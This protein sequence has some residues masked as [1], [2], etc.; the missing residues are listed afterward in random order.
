MQ[1]FF[2]RLQTQGVNYC[3]LRWFDDLPLV[4]VGEDLD[5]LVSDDS[6]LTLMGNVSR[7]FPRGQKLDVYSE[8]GVHTTHWHGIPYFP[9]KLSALLLRSVIQ[10]PGGALVPSREAHFLSLAYHAVFHKGF[11]SGISAASSVT[12]RPH[13]PDHDYVAAL[14]TLRDD[15][16]LHRLEISLEGLFKYLKR[17]GYFPSPDVLEFLGTKNK[18]VASVLRGT[19][20]AESPSESAVTVFVIRESALPYVSDLRGA[21]SSE[22]FEVLMDFPLTSG[23]TAIVRESSRGGNWAKGPFPK[24]GGGPAHLIVT[25]D[26]FPRK[27]AELGR[28]RNPFSTNLRVPEV[29]QKI[30]DIV[31]RKSSFLQHSNSVHSTDNALSTEFLLR[32]LLGSAETRRVYATAQE[33]FD[34]VSDAYQRME[35]GLANSRRSVTGFSQLDGSN[36]A[37]AT[38]TFRRQCI[39]F[40]ERELSAREKLGDQLGVVPIAEAGSNFFSTVLIEGAVP[41]KILTPAQVRLT[42]QFLKACAA[43]GLA[44]VD[45]SPSNM[46]V[47]PKGAIHFLDFEFFQPVASGYPIFRSVALRGVGRKSTLEVPKGFTG[48]GSHYYRRWFRHTLLPRWIYVL[49]L[50]DSTVRSLQNLFGYLLRLV[51]S[52]PNSAAIL[53]PAIRIKLAVRRKVLFVHKV[54][55]MRAVSGA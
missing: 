19:L 4:P 16:G 39:R 8:S 22:G 7:V 48:R 27:N 53:N 45:F 15:L 46:L 54:G 5:L 3:V 51:D 12:G 47:S 6:V 24:S 26:V 10:G 13:K 18:F 38:K 23:Q 28:G 37:L 14:T 43:N 34:D 9:K 25:V 36:S 30:R 2:E 11:D 1:G 52:L 33:I 40:L 31:N 32:S 21:I 41:P 49:D 44:P 29:K 42:R 17:S 35:D 50:S 20:E 55:L